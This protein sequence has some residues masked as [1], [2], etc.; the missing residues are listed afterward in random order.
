[1]AP[2]SSSPTM[3]RVLWT[4]TVILRRPGLVYVLVPAAPYRVEVRY[5]SGVRGTIEFLPET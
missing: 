5:G 3:G 1:L 4:K 2:N